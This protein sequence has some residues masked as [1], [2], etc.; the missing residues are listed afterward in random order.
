MLLDVLSIGEKTYVDIVSKNDVR[1]IGLASRHFF[2]VHMIR[3]Y[4]ANRVPVEDRKV[5]LIKTD[6]TKRLSC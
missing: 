4:L 6:V 5:Y 1:K 3:F 2:D